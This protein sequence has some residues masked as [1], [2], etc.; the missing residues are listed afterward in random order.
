MTSDWHKSEGSTP[1]LHTVS[2][3]NRGL[4][5]HVMEGSILGHTIPIIISNSPGR[6]RFTVINI[7][8]KYFRGDTFLLRTRQWEASGARYPNIKFGQTLTNRQN[9]D[10]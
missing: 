6:G 5:T 7:R 10:W 2:Q 3:T 1:T 9:T 8:A 4:I